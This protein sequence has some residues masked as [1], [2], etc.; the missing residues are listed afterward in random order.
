VSELPAHILRGQ[1]TRERLMEHAVQI[2]TREGLE[3]LTIGRLAEATG[4]AKATLLGHYASKEQLQLAT[5]DAG[6]QQFVAN[7]IVPASAL[8]EGIVRLSGLLE[9]WM[10]YVVSTEGGCLYASVTAEFD[11]RPGAVRDRIR[12]SLRVWLAALSG[13]VVLAKQLKHLMPKTDPE[14]LVFSLHGIELALN[15]RVQ[16]FEE[17]AA[18][19]RARAAMEAQIQQVATALGKKLL[20]SARA[21]ARR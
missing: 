4:I 11:A 10:S 8:P 21:Q 6:S 9:R 13:Q 15:L 14:Q 12:D 1:Q 2:A 20:A 3:A 18:I 19:A 7:V 5:L 16:L 17:R